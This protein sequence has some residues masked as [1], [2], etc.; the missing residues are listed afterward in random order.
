MQES[1]AIKNTPRFLGT[2][3]IFFLIGFILVSMETLK[4]QDFSMVVVGII[5]Q[6]TPFLLIGTTVSSFIGVFVPEE[7]IVQFFPKK[8]IVATLSAIGIG[9]FLPLCDCTVI[10]VAA[11]LRKKGVPVHAVVTFITAAPV[12]NPIVILSTI[13]A[14]PGTKIPIYRVVVGIMIAILTGLILKIFYGS[15]EDDKNEILRGNLDERGSCC[16]GGC[17]QN[18]EHPNMV[19]QCSSENHLAKED[20]NCGCH[21]HID[22]SSQNITTN[23]LMNAIVHAGEEFLRV[24]KVFIVGVMITSAIQIFIPQNLFADFAGETFSS[25]FIMMMLAFIMSICSTSDSFIGRSFLYKVP[26]S[27]VFGFIVFG[28]VLDLK[29]TIMMTLF[30]KKKFVFAFVGV[31]FVVAFI[32]ISIASVILFK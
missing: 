30:F 3:M 8:G 11:L 23:K 22:F 7:R 28:P 2:M 5:I 18:E 12:V 17:D 32:V 21:S 4:L 25:V 29:N 9:V 15:K 31:A 24:S 19:H 6:A 27:G 26:I 14:F 10:P 13:Y 16:G 1:L 20:K